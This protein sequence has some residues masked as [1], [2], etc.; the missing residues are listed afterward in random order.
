MFEKR[1]LKRLIE[2]L[3]TKKK[4]LLLTTSNRWAKSTDVPKST[5]LAMEVKKQLG[6][7]AVLMDVTK[8]K[9]YSCEGDVSLS[10][11]NICGVKGCLLKDK[12]KNPSGFHRCWAS[13][14]N[15]DDE[16]WKISKELLNSDAV[17]FFGSIRWGQMNSEYQKLLE[18]LT[19]LENRHAS[20]G[21][22]NILKNIEAGLIF[23]GH[24]WNAWLVKLIQK[25]ALDFYGFKTPSKLSFYWQ[26][27]LNPYNEKLEDYKKA[28]QKF[29]EEFGLE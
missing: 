22:E 16:L 6:K 15:K 9:I 19:W 25:K 11:G 27:T 12:S 7:K 14:H 17:I 4:V 2:H 24:N 28:R 26:Y 1:K 8:M 23:T 18:R 29:L 10:S 13:F 21:E 3:K 20:L 5:F